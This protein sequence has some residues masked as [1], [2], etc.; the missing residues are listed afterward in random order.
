M[1]SMTDGGINPVPRRLATPPAGTAKV[2][3]FHAPAA[4]CPTCGVRRHCLPLGLDE[5]T[6][7]R[8]D[9]MFAGPRRLARREVLY[10][11]GDPFTALHAVRLGTLKTVV[12]GEDGREQITGYHMAGDI[13]GFDA[14]GQ[15]CHGCEVLALEDSE[16]CTL[17]FDRLGDVAHDPALLQN[18]FDLMAR[19]LR[20]GRDLVV[21]LGGM[22]ADERLATFL[23]NLS[24]RYRA[25]GFSASEFV[26]RMTREEIASFLGLKLET[27]S[28]SFSRLQGEGLIQVQGRAIKLLDSAGLARAAGHA[29]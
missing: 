14:F 8:L 3:S 24:E 19:D 11:A 2:M 5:F 7:H 9:R 1:R 21:L 6:A 15:A 17:P 25:R 27:V 28:R 10:R 18:L 26:L 20:R 29:C 16:V 4:Q 12:I 13:I 23:L 22:T